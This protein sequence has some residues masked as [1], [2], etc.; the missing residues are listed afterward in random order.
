[1]N[2]IIAATREDKEEIL[3]IYR[4]MLYGSADWNE[5]YPDELTEEICRLRYHRGCNRIAVPVI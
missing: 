3:A 5:C 2:R 4:T 1:M